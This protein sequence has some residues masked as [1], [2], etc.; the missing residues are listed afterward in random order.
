LNAAAQSTPMQ[1]QDTMQAN[2]EAATKPPAAPAVAT[3]PP[4]PANATNK[5]VPPPATLTAAPVPDTYGLYGNI[6]APSDDVAHP[7]RLNMPF[8]GIGELKI[9]NQNELKEREIL[10]QLADLSDA[11]IRTKLSEWPPYS[12]MKLSDEGQM[13][14]RIE[15]FREER[16]KIARDRAHDLGLTLTP[17]QQARF[18]KDYWT[19]RLAMDQQLAK[20]FSGAYAAQSQKMKETLFREFSTPGTTIPTTKPPAP[21]PVAQAKPAAASPPLAQTPPAH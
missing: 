17:D 5:G 16:A 12:K 1:M 20:Q 8:P 10:E 9:P 3:P 11:D 2:A 7:I 4:A 13:L 21:P 19:L 15:Q 6:L 14:I 18:E